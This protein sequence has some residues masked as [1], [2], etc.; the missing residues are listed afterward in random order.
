MNRWA[1]TAVVSA[2]LVSGLGCGVSSPNTAFVES[3]TTSPT[4]LLITWSSDG[5]PSVPVC[6]GATQNC[7]QNFTV[8]DQ[9]TGATVTVPITAMSYTA[10]NPNDS[11]AVRVNGFDGQGNSIS[12]AYEVVPIG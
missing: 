6:N 9:T 3:K 4:S 10:P 11:Y 2:I 12:S 5:N 1:L 8:L 7:K